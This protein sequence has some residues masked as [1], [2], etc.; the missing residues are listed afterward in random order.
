MSIERRG[1]MPA[2][3][4]HVTVEVSRPGEYT[5]RYVVF[6]T[7]RPAELRAAGL[8]TALMEDKILN[9]R[10]GHHMDDNHHAFRLLPA[11]DGDPLPKR[12]LWASVEPIRLCYYR[13]YAARLLY[14]PAVA[15]LFP[16]GIP[17]DDEQEE[18]SPPAGL[19]VRQRAVGRFQRLVEY[20]NIGNTIWPNWQKIAALAYLATKP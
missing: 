8:V 5:H 18:I 3:H 20:A 1:T 2:P 16:E 17:T 4:E 7:A 12:V 14:M 6:Y 11:N 19:K 10:A 13:M 9:Q 15:A